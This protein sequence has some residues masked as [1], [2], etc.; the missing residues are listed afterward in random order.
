MDRARVQRRHVDD[1]QLTRPNPRRGSGKRGEEQLKSGWEQ[2]STGGRMS[3]PGAQLDLHHRPLCALARAQGCRDE[4]TVLG[5]ACRQGRRGMRGDP[6][7]AS[8]RGSGSG[9]ETKPKRGQGTLARMK[10]GGRGLEGAMSMRAK[11]RREQCGG[12]G[13]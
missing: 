5:R 10:A 6:R 3:Q 11:K 12:L 9:R 2:G 4:V 13:T 7:S 1:Q 8:A